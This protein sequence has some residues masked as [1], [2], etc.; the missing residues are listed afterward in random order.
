MNF[1]RRLFSLSFAA[2]VI[3]PFTA[4]AQV[5][6]ERAV[7]F[8]VP[9]SAGST[10]DVMARMVG[11]RLASRLKQPF[12]VE[13]R[14]GAG[15]AIGVAAVAQAPADGYTLLFTSSSP[16]V[17]APLLDSNVRY[18]PEKDLAPVALI[19]YVPLLLVSHPDLPARNL[20]ELI[21]L[22]KA[23]P[24][25]YSYASN[26]NGSNSHM[27]MELLKMAT[28]TYMVHIPYRGPAQAE[29]DVIGGQATLMF[30]SLTTGMN[31]VKAGRLKAY[32][33]SSAKADP[34][35]PGQVPLGAQGVP[36]LKNFDVVGW[37]GVMA[38]HGSPAPVITTLNREI[39]AVLTDPEFKAQ[40][41]AKS[42]TTF[43]PQPAEAMGKLIRD[44]LKK[45]GAVIKTAN[46]KLD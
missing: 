38:P 3:A 30:D 13:N 31:L 2:A 21:A 9:F 19:G 27:A 36:A 7:K 46:I 1:V 16:L 44:D 40:M 41:V 25:K 15:G 5:Y 14:S 32:G 8:I 35:A 10:A 45:W 33:I 26:G 4:S 17:V 22:A 42:T 34:L 43:A 6:P 11:E 28:G 39:Q 24:G 37:V 20:G 18:N 12:V 23:N 29:M